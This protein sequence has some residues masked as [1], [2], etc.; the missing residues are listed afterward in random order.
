MADHA[1]VGASI[2]AVVF[3]V[4]GAWSVGDGVPI[5][6]S[7]VKGIPLRPSRSD[8][9]GVRTAARPALARRTPIEA[10]GRRLSRQ[11]HCAVRTHEMREA[12][13]PALR[14]QA[15]DGHVPRRTRVRPGWSDTAV[16]PTDQISPDGAVTTAPSQPAVSG[17]PG[18]RVQ[19]SPSHRSTAGRRSR[20]D[21][22]EPTA[23]T[24]VERGKE[25]GVISSRESP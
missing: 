2:T 18:S 24:S 9:L 3:G 21:R 15:P 1:A 20:P 17:T 14:T 6:F 5:W 10:L 12:T 23:H 19:V 11:D 4:G 22:N 8:Q 16:E 13:C 25:A 7:T